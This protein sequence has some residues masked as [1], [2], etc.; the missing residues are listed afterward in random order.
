MCS[1]EKEFHNKDRIQTQVDS[2]LKLSVC[3]AV[4]TRED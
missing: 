2:G 3:L 4:K 1:H